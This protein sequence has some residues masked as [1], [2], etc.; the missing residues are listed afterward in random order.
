MASTFRLAPGEERTVPL[1]GAGSAGYAW[2]V[3]VTG[4]PGTV[5][6]VVRAAPRPPVA[7]GALPYGGSQPQEL[8][9]RAL[10]AGRAQVHLELSRPFGAVRTPRESLH[11]IVVVADD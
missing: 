6:A 11:L 9:L 5:E 1:A 3:Q 7:P 8:I 4:T 2:T 10:R